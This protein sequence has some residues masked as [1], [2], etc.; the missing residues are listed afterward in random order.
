MYF[1]KPDRVRAHIASCK[2]AFCCLQHLCHNLRLLGHPMS[3]EAIFVEL[4]ILSREGA[5]ERYALPSP[6]TAPRG[7]SCVSALPGSSC[8]LTGRD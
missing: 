2:L 3:P 1:W 4:R 7:T 5:H 6:A 8:P